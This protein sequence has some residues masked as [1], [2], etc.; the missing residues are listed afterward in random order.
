MKTRSL[1]CFISLVLISGVFA[2]QSNDNQAAAVTEI[3]NKYAAAVQSKNLSE[4]EKYVVATDAFSMFE[5][6]HI[7]WGWIDYRDNHLGPELKEFKEIQYSFSD[8]KTRVSGDMAYA[9]FKSHIAVKMELR[10]VEG[11]SLATAILMKTADGWKIQHIHTSRI[12]PKKPEEK[13]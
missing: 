3:L 11:E 4:V 2:Q 13:K 8:I 9:T 6:G 5:G 1:I 7:N 10:E 12:P